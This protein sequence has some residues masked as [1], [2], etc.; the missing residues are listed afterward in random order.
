MKKN[1]RNATGFF[2]IDITQQ[3]KCFMQRKYLVKY[4][5]GSKP[6]LEPGIEVLNKCYI[7]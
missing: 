5:D 7:L 3:K 2:H 4:F 6:L 1:E